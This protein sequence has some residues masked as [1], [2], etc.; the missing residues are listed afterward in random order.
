[1]DQANVF[2]MNIPE[3][4]WKLKVHCK[5]TCKSGTLQENMQIVP[6]LGN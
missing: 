2:N 6:S 1:M 3:R 4:R 5:K